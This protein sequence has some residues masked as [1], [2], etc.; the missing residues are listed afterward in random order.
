MFKS[1]GHKAVW[2]A[3][4]DARGG[5]Y[6]EAGVL[7]FKKAIVHIPV[8]RRMLQLDT[9]TVNNGQNSTTTYTRMRIPV[10]RQLDFR[11]RMYP[12][13]IFSSIGKV[14][15]M[16]DIKVGFE[17]FDS[18]Y[19]VKSNDDARIAVLLEDEG[20]RSSMVGLSRPFFTLNVAGGRYGYTNGSHSESVLYYNRRGVIRTAGELG[21]IT[22][23]LSAMLERLDSMGV[24]A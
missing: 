11:F 2:E 3:F 20:L 23:I 15:G 10:Q 13:N 5:T 12:E 19:I 7:I 8:Q 1:V 4:A 24:T 16:Q 6:E 18:E 9:Y 14:F 21:R 17:E 22:N